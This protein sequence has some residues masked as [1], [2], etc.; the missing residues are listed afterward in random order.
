MTQSMR[1]KEAAW[2][3]LLRLGHQPALGW[4]EEGVSTET[5]PFTRADLAERF[6]CFRLREI[7]PTVLAWVT[8]RYD[9]VDNDHSG[10]WAPRLAAVKVAH[11]SASRQAFEALLDFGLTINGKALVQTG[12][13]LAE[14][15]GMLAAEGQQS[16]GDVL[17]DTVT[18]S[19]SEPHR[20]AAAGALELMA[21]TGLLPATHSRRLATLLS[22]E[23]RAPFERSLLVITLSYLHPEQPTVDFS[24]RLRVWAIERE[25]ALGWRSIEALARHGQLLLYPDIL[26]KRLSIQRVGTGWDLLPAASCTGWAASVI[27]ELYSKDI[28]TFSAAVASVLWT[29][30]WLSAVELIYRLNR[31]HG[32]SNQPALPVQVEEALVGRTR[33]LQTQTGAELGI[34]TCLARLAPEALVHERWEDIWADWLPQARGALA[35]ALGEAK[36]AT[37]KARD[38][39]V[40]LL[41]NLV[42]DGQYAVR[43]SAYRGMAK[44]SPNSLRTNYITWSSA[45]IVELRQRAAEAYVWV[46]SDK[47][48]TAVLGRTY[49]RLAVDPERT[50]REAADRAGIERRERLLAERYLSHIVGVGGRTNKE[51]LSAWR[52]GHALTQV[53]ND[54]SVRELRKHLTTRPLPPHVRYW[55]E[56]IMKGISDRWREV[57]RKWPEPWLGWEGAIEESQ[58]KL[59]LRGGQTIEVRCSLW[60]QP[61]PTPSRPHSWGGAVW[62][63]DLSWTLA[64]HGEELAL[65]LEDGRHGTALAS[66]ISG[67]LV[68]LSGQGPYPS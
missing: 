25:D 2:D 7:P 60:H 30:D 43:R 40:Q 33:K 32:R 26:S 34:F 24:E 58:G 45:P 11:S 9:M 8:D 12:D 63:P 3:T 36:C 16:I 39:A 28:A 29:Q 44:Q 37:P 65:Y 1:L 19:T 20:E 68:I 51:I 54:V 17:V 46:E 56:R 41:N 52:Y 5:N 14:L 55:V 22:D 13:A 6:A 47:R 27:G 10:E 59:V 57:T 38:R 31:T 67:E 18:D 35:D 4:F 48:K 62:V 66:R 23:K 49:R 15:A 61:S 42:R 50:V 21:A 64:I 53:G